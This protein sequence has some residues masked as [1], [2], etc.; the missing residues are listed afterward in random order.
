MG[1]NESGQMLPG[2]SALVHK[3]A[4]EIRKMFPGRTPISSVMLFF[5]GAS[6]MK[7]FSSCISNFRTQKVGTNELNQIPHEVSVLVHKL[8]LEIGK[9]FPGRPSISSVMLFFMGASAM[10]PFSSFCF[11]SWAQNVGKNESNIISHEVSFL[12]HKFALEIRKM[13]SGCVSR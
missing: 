10:K 1:K 13:F 2:V 5:M 7:P 8:A 11:D 9:M 4:L 12:A 6:A 3:F